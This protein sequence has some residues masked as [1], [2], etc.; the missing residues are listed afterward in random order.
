VYIHAVPA[1]NALVAAAAAGAMWLWGTLWWSWQ[2]GDEAGRRLAAVQLAKS[3]VAARTEIVVCV[4]V[5]DH[6]G[7]VVALGADLR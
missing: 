1:E 3:K 2:A 7:D 5:R 4:G 6:D